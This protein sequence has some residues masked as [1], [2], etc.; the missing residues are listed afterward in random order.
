LKKIND[1]FSF[2]QTFYIDPF[3][4]ENKDRALAVQKQVKKLRD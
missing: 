1:E 2:P 3:L 4:L